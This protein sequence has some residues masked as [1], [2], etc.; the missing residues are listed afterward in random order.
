[1]LNWN[2]IEDGPPEVEVNHFSKLVLV[3]SINEHG[4]KLVCEAVYNSYTEQWL[5][6]LTQQ[7]ITDW[8]DFNLPE[9]EDK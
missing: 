6:V 1:M 7:E 9:S 5:C 8:A 2:K 3:S 4:D